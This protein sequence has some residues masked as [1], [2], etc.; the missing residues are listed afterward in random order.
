MICPECGSEY[1]EGFT[2]CGSCD[3]DLVAAL[4][5]D[6][7]DPAIALVK[8]Y[9]T[10]DAAVIP[11]V[12]SLFGDA[13]IE[14]MTKGEGI[15][16]LFGLGRFGANFNNTIGPVEFFVRAEDVEEAKAI[17]ATLEKPTSFVDEW[18]SSPSDENEPR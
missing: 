16:D 1:R 6:D 14:Y 17:I 4:P 2:H 10:G 7:S 13:N 11:L 15:Q 5:P 3:V 12:E 9:E 18:E 8:V